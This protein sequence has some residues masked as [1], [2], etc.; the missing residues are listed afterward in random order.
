MA[1][2]SP[3]KT[4]AGRNGGLCL[5]S[6]FVLDRRHKLGYIVSC[7]VHRGARSRGVVIVGSDTVPRPRSRSLGR[8]EARAPAAGSDRARDPAAHKRRRPSRAGHGPW[9][10]VPP[11]RAV[12]EGPSGFSPT[13]TTHRA[14][15]P[16]AP[17]L[18]CR[19]A[20]RHQARSPMARALRR[21]PLRCA[22]D[23]NRRRTVPSTLGGEKCLI[24]MRSAPRCDVARDTRP[25]WL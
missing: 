6:S 13:P 11:K 22:L 3:A 17:P 9:P 8:R 2:T 10:P 4:G 20:P 14:G 7:P 1:G 15:S 24:R 18:D 12:R 21:R 23:G 5:C 19:K 16:F 25:L